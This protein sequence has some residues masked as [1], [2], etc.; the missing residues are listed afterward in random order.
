MVSKCANPACS[1][2]FHYLRE[3]KIFRVEVEVTPPGGISALSSQPKNEIPNGNKN[4]FLV[5]SRKPMLK[6]EHFWLCG[7]CSQSMSLL[8]DKDN[9]IS[10]IPKF[11]ARA[12]IAS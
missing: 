12:A 9:G 6:A 4:P 5:S 10:V 3:G 2:P 11:R 7:P 1:T 8:F